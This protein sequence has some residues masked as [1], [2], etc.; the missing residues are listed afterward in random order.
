V[1]VEHEKADSVTNQVSAQKRSPP[2]EKS[3]NVVANELAEKQSCDRDMQ[4]CTVH[5]SDEIEI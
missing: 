3:Y 4:Q 2:S 1:D 5:K